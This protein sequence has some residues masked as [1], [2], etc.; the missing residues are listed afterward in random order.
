MTILDTAE[1]TGDGLFETFIKPHLLDWLGEKGVNMLPRVKYKQTTDRGL[2]ITSKEDE[3]QTIEVGTV[4]TAL[5]LLPNTGLLNCLEASAPEVSA[6]G[7][8][9]SRA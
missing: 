8:A 1:E 7:T 5:P 9:G 6:V 4:V 3:R 2:I